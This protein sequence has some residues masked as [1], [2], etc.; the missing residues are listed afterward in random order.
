[1]RT[2][3]PQIQLR[4]RPITVIS[5]IT[6]VKHKILLMVVATEIIKQRLVI[7][8]QVIKLLYMS[9]MKTRK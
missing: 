1:M 2:P 4:L 7:M 9:A 8:H 3:I 5:K 6:Q